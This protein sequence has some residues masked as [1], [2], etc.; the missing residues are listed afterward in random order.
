MSL[1]TLGGLDLVSFEV[2]DRVRFGGRQRLAIHTLIGGRRVIDTLGRDD[3][4]I[5]W[6]GVLSG[7]EAGSRARELD[8][9]RVDGQLQTLIWDAFC[10]S[11]IIEHLKLTFTNPWWIPYRISCVVQQDLAQ[12]STGNPPST[13]TSLVSDLLAASLLLYPV[14]SPS[15]LQSL[16]A[17]AAAQTDVAI[18]ITQV[19]STFES[20]DVQ[21]LVSSAGSLAQLTCAQGYLDRSLANMTSGDF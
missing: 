7:N 8:S 4:A 15:L 9:M 21:Q 19:G 17:I 2:P 14:G 12:D 16:T 20:S 13:V 11:I 10:F 3:D 6:S 18:G 1:L 5:A